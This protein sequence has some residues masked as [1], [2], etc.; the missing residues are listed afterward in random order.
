MCPSALIAA[1]RIAVLPHDYR[2]SNGTF[3]VIV[4]ERDVRLVQKREHIILVSIQTLAQ[5]LSLAVI[6]LCLDQ[7]SKTKLDPFSSASIYRLVK[8]FPM[9][10]QSDS[11]L[12]QPFEL[13]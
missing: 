6:P 10:P 3:G 12:D 4:T 13:F 7:F 11:I 8:F 1:I 2:R 5:T 9:S